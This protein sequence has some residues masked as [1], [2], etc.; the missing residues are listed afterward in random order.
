MAEKQID[1]TP[2]C[3]IAPM[4]RVTLQVLAEFQKSALAFYIQKAA[5]T[6][7]F[8]KCAYQV[9]QAFSFDTAGQSMRELIGMQ[10]RCLDPMLDNSAAYLDSPTTLSATM[11]ETEMPRLI[12]DAADYST[13]AHEQEVDSA[14]R[15]NQRF[16]DAIKIEAEIC[17]ISAS[18][19]TDGFQRGIDLILEAQESCLSAMEPS[20]V[21]KLKSFGAAKNDTGSTD[22]IHDAEFCAKQQTDTS[23][24]GRRSYDRSSLH[25]KSP[26]G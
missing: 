10:K 14:I 4:F 12:R 2:S 23:P 15:H 3:P 16:A 18:D 21:V 19:A 13:T 8:A 11:R 9:Q 24:A 20:E 25:L 7:E 1:S 22:R 5:S 6:L 26:S 17:D